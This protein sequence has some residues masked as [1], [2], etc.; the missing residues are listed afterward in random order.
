MHALPGRL[1]SIKRDIDIHAKRIRL[2]RKGGDIQTLP[3]SDDVISYLQPYLK[4]RRHRA[5]CRAAFVS[6]RGL[7]LTQQAISSAV[8]RCAAAARLPKTRITPHS[9][10]HTFA[11]CLLAHGENLQTIRVLMNHKSLSTTARYLHTQDEQ[12]NAAVNGITLKDS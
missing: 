6:V 3:L 2:H 11:C 10:R 1:R 12:L 4:E 9:L 5:H 8:R 7:R